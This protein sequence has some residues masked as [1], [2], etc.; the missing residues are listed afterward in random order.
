MR[1]ILKLLLL[2]NYQFIMTSTAATKNRQ[3]ATACASIL[4]ER[5]AREKTLSASGDFNHL[6]RSHAPEEHRLTTRGLSVQIK[7]DFIA[8]DLKLLPGFID[9]VM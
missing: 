9:F 8:N 7:L 3:D 2:S 4:Y 1:G 6:R 5:V